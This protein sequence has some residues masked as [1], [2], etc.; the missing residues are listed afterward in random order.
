MKDAF[1]GAYMIYIFI[2]FTI[3]FILFISLIL[4]YG[5]AFKI[6]N[7]IIEYIEE[8]E[9]YQ[10]AQDKIDNYIENDSLYRLDMDDSIK[11]TDAGSICSSYGY[12]V[13]HHSKNGSNEG[14]YT[15]YT[16]V[17]WDFP[18]FRLHS[19]WMIKG[20]TRPVSG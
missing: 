3:I 19:T 11:V 1:G 12:C 2:G 17:K 8:Y 14:Y 15:V 20:E 7:T 4:K 5:Q 10:R 13:V 9:S 16:F 6:K 18:F